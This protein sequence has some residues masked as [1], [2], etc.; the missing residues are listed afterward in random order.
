MTQPDWPIIRIAAGLIVD[1]A[2]RVLVVRNAERKRSCR[3]AE[4]SSRMKAPA[5]R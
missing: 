1:G 5:T 2:G 3:P 4:T